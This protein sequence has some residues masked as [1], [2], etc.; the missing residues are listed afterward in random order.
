M[1]SEIVVRCAKQAAVADK[2]AAT[3][4]LTEGCTD[5]NTG[6]GILS[7]IGY[8]KTWYCIRESGEIALGQ[9]FTDDV[10]PLE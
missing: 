1:L 6:E 2:R 3:L 7:E 5:W 9:L 8:R 4:D 10:F